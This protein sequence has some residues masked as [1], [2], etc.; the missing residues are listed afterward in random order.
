MVL[1]QNKLTQF[2]TARNLQTSVQNRWVSGPP[3]WHHSFVTST[4]T[5][6]VSN[7]FGHIIIIIAQKYFFF[8]FTKSTDSGTKLLTDSWKF[9]HTIKL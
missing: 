7:K 9:G 5:K 6:C 4:L 1:H 2:E 3:T 8:N